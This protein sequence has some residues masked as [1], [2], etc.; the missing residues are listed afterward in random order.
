VSTFA[1]VSVVAYLLVVAAAFSF[2][3]RFYGIFRAVT[4]GVHSL[5]AAAIWPAVAPTP[6]APAFL[7]LHGA[8]FVHSLF[9]VRPR[10]R[11]LPYRALISIPQ[12]FFSAGTLLSLPWA[13]ASL[14]TDQLAGLW[15]PY[16]LALIGVLQSLSSRR[17]VIDVLVGDGVKVPR[18]ARH[19]GKPAPPSTRPLRVT[20]LTDPH[21]GPFMLAAPTR[22]S[23]TRTSPSCA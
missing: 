7:W 22:R 14:F 4:L 21:L 23:P 11:P 10:L 1:L 16:T 12:S 18:L 9:L 19:G 20:Q 6:V 3:S 5:I 2:R 13:V 17:E 15:V 8:V